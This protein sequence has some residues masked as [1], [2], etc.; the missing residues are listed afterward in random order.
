MT[1]FT[2]SVICQTLA[3]HLLGT[4]L[5]QHAQDFGRQRDSQSSLEERHVNSST[6]YELYKVEWWFV[7]GGTGGRAVN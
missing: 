1:S 3:E 6:K 4:D 2:H 5:V 7:Q